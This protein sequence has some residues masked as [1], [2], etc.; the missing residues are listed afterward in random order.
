MSLNPK[1]MQK[2]D[3]ATQDGSIVTMEGAAADESDQGL[4]RRLVGGGV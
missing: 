1:R 3:N 2:S 4:A